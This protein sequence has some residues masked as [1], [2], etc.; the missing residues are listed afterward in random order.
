MCYFA[1]ADVY[2]QKKDYRSAIEQFAKGLQIAPNVEALIKRA[3][4]YEHIGE[5]DKAL[6][7]FKAV[8]FIAPTHKEALEGVRR[9]G[10]REG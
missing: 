10:Q 9:L 1:K 5:A 6:A 3:Q 4:A 2:F 8:L 7:D